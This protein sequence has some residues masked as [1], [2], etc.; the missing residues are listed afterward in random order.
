[1]EVG[2]AKPNDDHNL[3]SESARSLKQDVAQEDGVHKKSVSPD[4]QVK[5]ASVSYLE[6]VVMSDASQPREVI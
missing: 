6:N 5:A 1:M 3:K 4:P 2:G